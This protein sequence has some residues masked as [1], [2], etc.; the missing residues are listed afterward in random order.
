MNFKKILIPMLL[1]SQLR[2]KYFILFLI[3]FMFSEGELPQAFMKDLNNK[4]VNIYDFIKDGPML[5]NFW[6][7][8]C[9]PCKKEMKYL[10]I[11][12]EKYSKYGFKVVSINTD[13][14]RT[15]SRVKP[16]VNSKKYSFDVLSDPKSLFF[17]KMGG[18]Q[19]PY[20]ILFDEKGNITNKH[21]GYNPG[22]EIKF[23]REIVE[24]L[25][26][27]ISL[28]TTK[29]D[30][31]IITILKEIEKDTLLKLKSEKN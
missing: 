10:D 3:S 1:S 14:A 26:S 5:V 4:K 27:R 11:Y 15:F 22:D 29:I 19:C 6:F 13:N 18:Q 16:Y 7:L 24:L 2:K 17:R 23:E 30:S 31:S 9:E 8:A 28:D 20:T 25:E 21:V 12:N